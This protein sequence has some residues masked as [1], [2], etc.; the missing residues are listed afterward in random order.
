MFSCYADV[1]LN[2]PIKQS[3]TYQVPEEFVS[4]LQRGMR[5]EVK[6]RTRL[7]PAV[8]ERLHRN[9]VQEKEKLL[10]LREVLDPEPLVNSEQIELAYWMAE[11]Y[12]CAPG[13][14]LFKMFPKA[15]RPKQNTAI[16]LSAP[17]I[18]YVLNTEQKK[19]YQKISAEFKDKKKKA[20]S[21]HVLHGITGSGKTEIYIHLICD[22]LR[23]DR[24]ALLLVP[25]ISLTVQLIERLKRVFGEHLA[26]LHSGL[27]NTERFLAYCRSCVE[28]RRLR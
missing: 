8:V 13:E 22:A 9:P 2:L 28:K 27:K 18:E 4:K 1:L 3:Y 25:E 10:T 19:I 16:Q 20:L 23:M 11:H 5:V 26:L 15:K 17:R 14:A 21:A 12:L 24:T 6:F 7:L